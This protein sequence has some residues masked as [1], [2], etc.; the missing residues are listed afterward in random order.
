MSSILLHPL[1]CLIQ[2]VL[3]H[4]HCCKWISQH[5]LCEPWV[6]LAELIHVDSE[7]V[8]SADH[9]SNLF[10][11]VLMIQVILDHLLELQLLC[12]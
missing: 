7:S 3:E 4:L 1:Y 10:L 6:E 8:L 11:A 2:L 5:K 9:P 12:I